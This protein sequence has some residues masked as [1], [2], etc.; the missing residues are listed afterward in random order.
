MDYAIA[1]LEAAL[2]VLK[3]NI[4]IDTDEEQNALRRDE[5]VSFEAA[6]DALKQ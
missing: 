6:I 3:T 1:E 5:I 2:N 4:A